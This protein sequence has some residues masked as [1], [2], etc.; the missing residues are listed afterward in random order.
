M[1]DFKFY[2]PSG[3]IH[4]PKFWLIDLDD[5]LYSASAGMFHHIH[6]LMDD[7]IQKTLNV[8]DQVANQL[9]KDY[10]KRYGVTFLGLWLHHGIDPV[11]FLTQTHN[12]DISSV[13]TRGL[14]RQ[15]LISLPGQKILFTNAPRVFAERILKKIHMRDVFDAKYC[16]NDMKVF[17]QWCP[18]PSAAMLKKVLTNHHIRPTDACLIDDNLGNLKVAHQLGL[19]T[20]LC[21]GWHHHGSEIVRPLS[22]VDAQISHLR[23][24]PKIMTGRSK[25][26]NTKRFRKPPLL[27]PYG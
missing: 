5:S 2:Q 15:S 22:Y 26:K 13:K 9:R 10:W 14:M 6:V 18:K 12:V 3:C 24:I 4:R 25:T 1:S 17:G 16:V 8:N 20:V 19:Q 21:K 11:D 23:D 7:Y 27:N